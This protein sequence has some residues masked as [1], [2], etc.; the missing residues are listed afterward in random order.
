MKV[1]KS[2]LSPEAINELSELNFDE[3]SPELT[4]LFSS[5]I[6]SL[7]THG[8]EIV[9]LKDELSFK[10]ISEMLKIS[11]LKVQNLVKNNRI[12]N[13]KVGDKIVIRHEDVESYKKMIRSSITITSV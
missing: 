10:E 11:T 9:E 3:L 2:E 5:V 8:V 1:L 6:S 7:M 12:P 4:D 13:K